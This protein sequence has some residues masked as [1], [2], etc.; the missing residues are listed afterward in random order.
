MMIHRLTKR[1]PFHYGWLVVGAGTLCIFACLGIGRFALGM[2]LPS[3]ADPLELT[4]TQ[5]G[6]IS[7]ANFI[8]YLVSVLLCGFLV[9]RLGSRRVIFFSLLLVGLSMIV[10]SRA[11]GFFSVLV[12]YT[13]T[14]MGSGAS[15]VPMM[16]LVSAWFVS[17]QRG[18]ATGFVVIGSGFAIIMAGKLIPY[19]N[20]LDPWEGWRINWL[21]LGTVVLV[22]AAVCFL[23][24][25]DRPSDVGLSVCGSKDLSV[26]SPGSQPGMRKY[27]IRR[28]AIYHMGAIYF[29][30][31]YTYVIYATFIVTSLVRDRGFS[32]AAAGSLW[33]L[34]GVMSLISGPV[35]GT[36][37]D[38]VGRKA[39]LV[40]VFTIQM[41]SY[42]LMAINLP[43]IFL[44]LSI[45]FYGIVA[46][47][48]P[49]IMAALVGDYVGPDK[50]TRVF[51]FITFIFGL[52]Q[53]AGPAV[54]GSLADISGSFS[55]SFYMATLLAGSAVVLSSFFKMPERA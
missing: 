39:G 48:I 27:E 25:R 30:F 12:F 41:V 44:H 36:I 46:W 14:G 23:I 49:S 31:G 43:G 15:N 35:F 3:M 52:G 8:G 55:G 20:N 5:M 42:L 7:T 16:A 32:E 9:A 26:T 13:L 22:V 4:Y 47:S 33:A 1:L 24:L 2:L 45:V 29:L 6:F 21:I 54:A 37:S 11:E 10:V 17:R 40:M 18:R 53:I 28:G 19:I 50:A 34:V 38:K 51:G